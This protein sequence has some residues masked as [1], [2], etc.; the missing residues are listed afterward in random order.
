MA[1]PVV[2]VGWAEEPHVDARRRWNIKEFCNLALLVYSDFAAPKFIIYER[3]HW[4][5]LSMWHQS[6][7]KSVQMSRAAN[8]GHS[9]PSSTLET[10]VVRN[11][12]SALVLGAQCLR[13]SAASCLLPLECSFFVSIWGM[14]VGFG[15]CSVERGSPGCPG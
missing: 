11:V 9:S 6:E 10:S 5:S 14:R 2:F 15:E 8:C 3:I 4:V 12:L 13:F 1:I 7:L